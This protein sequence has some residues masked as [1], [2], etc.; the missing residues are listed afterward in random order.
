MYIY[1]LHLKFNITTHAK[2][3]KKKI[4]ESINYS[5]KITLIKYYNRDVRVPAYI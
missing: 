4:L 3:K 2:L 1:L 5:S